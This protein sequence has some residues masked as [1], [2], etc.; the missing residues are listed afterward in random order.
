MPNF[1]GQPYN[2]MYFDQKISFSPIPGTIY[3]ITIFGSSKQAAPAPAS[4]AEASNLWMTEGERLI[5][6]CAK[7]IL[8]QDVILD[9]DAAA[10]CIAG[11]QEALTVL[12][13]ASASM[14]KTG[15]IQ[16]MAF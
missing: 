16:P 10:A 11:E 2:Y 14:T 7:R 15:S 13:G 1:I 3:T 8:Y 6:Q 5:R 9:A 12:K 4:D